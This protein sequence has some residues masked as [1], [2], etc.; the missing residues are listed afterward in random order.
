MA[1]GGPSAH[2]DENTGG[3]LGAGHLESHSA[4]YREADDRV[5]ELCEKATGKGKEVET[6][7]EM[8]TELVWHM[9]ERDSP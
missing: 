1:G 6:E 9:E 4:S 7:A 8:S 3:G 5:S 2:P